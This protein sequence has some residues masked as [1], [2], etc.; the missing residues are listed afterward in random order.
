MTQFPNTNGLHVLHGSTWS[1]VTNFVS[2]AVCRRALPV[3]EVFGRHLVGVEVR[4]GGALETQVAQLLVRRHAH[5]A[6]LGDRLAFLCERDDFPR[7]RP[8]RARLLH[9]L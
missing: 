3:R 5:R 4:H 1:L 9:P 8:A 7:M 2:P 6:K